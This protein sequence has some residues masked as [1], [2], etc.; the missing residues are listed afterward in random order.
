MDK[1]SQGLERLR[2]P[3]DLKSMSKAKARVEIAKDVIAALNTKKLVATSGNYGSIN[4]EKSSFKKFKYDTLVS[5]RDALGVSTNCQVCALGAACLAVVGRENKLKAPFYSSSVELS[6]VT[7]LRAQ[8]RE[9]FTPLQIA[10][11]ECAFEGGEAFA[12]YE[13]I[14]LNNERVSALID[15]AVNM[16]KEIDM[17]DTD[18]SDISD[19]LAQDDDMR[20]RTIFQNIIDNKGEFIL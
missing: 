11:I 10:L 1:V 15:T 7:A 20:M 6:H 2:K 3:I 19:L 16:F 17:S 4:I 8:L 9:Y 13:D 14:D 18:D 12:D 5:V